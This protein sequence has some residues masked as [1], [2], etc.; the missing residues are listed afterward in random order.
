VGT[1]WASSLGISLTPPA[2]ATGAVVFN[3]ADGRVL[4]F[5]PDPAGGYTRPPDLTANLVRNADGS[6]TLSYRSGLVLSFGPAGRLTSQAQEDQRVSYDYDASGRL[7][8]AGHSAGP[9]LALNY[10]TAGRLAEAAGWPAGHRGPDQHH[11]LG[12]RR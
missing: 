10:D 7:L 9:A 8:H 6:F 3:G 2:D 1:G 5:T 4:T 12:D 11:S